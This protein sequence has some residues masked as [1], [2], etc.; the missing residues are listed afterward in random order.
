MVTKGWVLTSMECR[1]KRWRHEEDYCNWYHGYNQDAPRTILA[2]KGGLEELQPSRLRR[3]GLFS[4]KEKARHW[5]E[6]ESSGLYLMPV[7][8]PNIQLLRQEEHSKLKI[9]C[10]P[11]TIPEVFG[12]SKCRTFL[13]RSS[14]NPDQKKFSQRRKQVR[15]KTKNLQRQLSL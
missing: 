13:E 4:G 5:W 3:Y 8:S 14:Q 6:M 7:Y 12:R 2:M 10:K 11:G 15:L 9:S 1:M